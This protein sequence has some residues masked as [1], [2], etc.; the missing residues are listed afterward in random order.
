ML[1]SSSVA[2]QLATSQEGL[3]TMNLVLYYSLYTNLNGMLDYLI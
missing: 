1:G 2:A 3:S